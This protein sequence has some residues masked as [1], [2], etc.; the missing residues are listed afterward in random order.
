VGNNAY[1]VLIPPSTGD[2]ANF[3]INT[4]KYFSKFE[5]SAGDRIQISGYT[6]SPEVLAD[7][8]SG[9]ALRDFCAWV[10][11]PEGHIVLDAAYSPTTSTLK[12]GFNDLVESVWTQLWR[13]SSCIWH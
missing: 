2:S 5:M 6:Y 1:N 9:A 3:Y 4:S 13:D 7:Q 8:V 11:R 10:N 12:D